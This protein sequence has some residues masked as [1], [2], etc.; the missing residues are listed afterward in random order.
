MEQCGALG[1]ISNCDNRCKNNLYIYFQIISC[2]YKR[3]DAEKIKGEIHKTIY[4][5]NS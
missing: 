2:M 5:A 1:I 4:G 3:V